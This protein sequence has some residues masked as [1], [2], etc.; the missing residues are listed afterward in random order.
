[1]KTPLNRH[2]LSGIKLIAILGMICFHA[3]SLPQIDYGV[4]ACIFFFIVSGFTTSYWHNESFDVK[5]NTVSHYYT[6]KL[7]S[8][9]FPYYSAFLLSIPLVIRQIK[10]ISDLK[11]AL[12]DSVFHLLFIQ[13]WFPSITFKFN[14]IAWFSGSLMFCYLFTPILLLFMQTQTSKRKALTWFITSLLLHLFLEY[15]SKTYPN[16][17]TYSIHSNPVIK[18]LEYVIGMELALCY[19]YYYHEICNNGLFSTL[20]EMISIVFSLIITRMIGK[21]GYKSFI[22]I[23]LCIIII[24]F[25]IGKGYMSKLL[26]LK[27]IQN[28]SSLQGFLYLFHYVVMNYIYKFLS[29]FGPKVL[30]EN[31]YIYSLIC[32]TSTIVFSYLMYWIQKKKP[33]IIRNS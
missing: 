1:M 19:K 9:S 21:D 29:S 25:V 20:M 6:K 14:A 16:V 10:T 7:S 15:C 4:I 32:I 18:C 2:A 13:C 31:K 3:G 28:L 17:F 22:L 30:Y 8:T 26:S 23:P 5:F 12:C 11:E 33:I 27:A 24:V